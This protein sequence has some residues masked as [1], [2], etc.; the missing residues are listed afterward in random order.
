MNIRK[1]S[2][3]IVEKMVA[4]INDDWLQEPVIILSDSSE[5]ELIEING[6][7]MMAVNTVSWKYVNKR[8]PA[9]IEHLYVT[10]HAELQSQMNIKVDVNYPDGTTKKLTYADIARYPY[11][12]DGEYATDNII[13]DIKIPSYQKGCI[14]RLQTEYL[15]T[16]A[17]F[18]NGIYLRG[19][20][21]V[22]DKFVNIILPEGIKIGLVNNEN[23]PIDTFSIHTPDMVHYT[24]HASNLKKLP[25]SME[26]HNPEEW[27]AGIH[28]SVPPKGK[29]SYTWNELGD[30]HLG[31]IDK[32][33]SLREHVADL[34]MEITS[35]DPDTII[36]EAFDIVRRNVRYHADFTDYH[37]FIP[38]KASTVI[39]RGY[40]DCKEMAS[41]LIMILRS[42]G[43]KANLALTY[44]A[45]SFQDL[46]S[47]PSMGSFGH[48]V[49]W[50]NSGETG[51]ILI[52]DPTIPFG[53]YD[54]SYY[55]LI[56]QKIFLLDSAASRMAKVD[57]T[58]D[59][60]CKVMTNSTI[61]NEHG[62]WVITGE[63]CLLGNLAF[64]LFPYLNK[65]KPD[66]EITFLNQIMMN[67]FEITP[68]SIDLKYSNSDSVVISY[69][70][71][72]TANYVHFNK[73]GLRLNRPS[74]LGGATK[75]T[76]LDKEGPLYFRGFEEVDEWT[77]DK[78]FNEMQSDK[79]VNEWCKG[80][81]TFS[82]NKVKRIFVMNTWSLSHNERSKAGQ[83]YKDYNKFQNCI[84]WE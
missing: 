52:L 37:S 22:V 64:S 83:F 50:V 53:T 51:E 36:K 67:L 12:V 13:N 33:L 6:N 40:G 82:K 71:D 11:V 79:I 5:Y 80:E 63:V 4:N 70:S 3:F 35:S 48:A 27:Y 16:Q 72:F 66:E 30:N 2:F 20:Y 29:K 75:Y 25:K 58:A 55:A 8:N 81:W 10:E 18:L 31:E 42:K 84:V 46:D 21:P 59:Y 47:F 19:K 44:S 61:K 34:T 9:V 28:C 1:P 26:M 39:G 24:F 15:L 74:L 68:V 54:K 49:V 69:T 77:I 7:N 32:I 17:E 45:G 73:D 41:L 65:L 14:I 43:V 60:V 38:R 78:K 76:T 57:K 23:L 62:K 56:D